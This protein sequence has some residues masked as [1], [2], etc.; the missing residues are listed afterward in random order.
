MD[1]DFDDKSDLSDNEDGNLFE[2]AEYDCEKYIFLRDGMLL[3]EIPSKNSWSFDSFSKRGGGYIGEMKIVVN[4][5]LFSFSLKCNL[6]DN[7]LMDKA[8]IETSGL[9]S[10]IHKSLFVSNCG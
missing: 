8:K 1:R 4:P 7:I 3:Q 2:S 9:L 5:D 6:F 10:S